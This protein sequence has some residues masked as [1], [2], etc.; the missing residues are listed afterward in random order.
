MSRSNIRTMAVGARAFRNHRMFMQQHL[1]SASRGRALMATNRAY[2]DRLAW[3]KRIEDSQA[4]T[5]KPYNIEYDTFLD[6]YSRVVMAFKINR[7][8]NANV[9]VFAAPQNGELTNNNKILPAFFAPS[10]IP[11]KGRLIHSF[12]APVNTVDM[13]G[14]PAFI[15]YPNA[16][17]NGAPVFV[18]IANTS[19]DSEQNIKAWRQLPLDKDGSPLFVA[20]PNHQDNNGRPVFVGEADAFDENKNLIYVGPERYGGIYGSEMF[21]YAHA[22]YI[23]PA[24]RKL[25]IAYENQQFD[26]RAAF[27]ARFNFIRPLNSDLHPRAPMLAIS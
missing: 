27:V 11:A 5:P 13:K 14:N 4:K 24:G 22:N 1:Q 9:E 7:L 19:V 16:E 3:Q 26:G 21:F 6:A 2:R 10:E 25:F 18:A 17:H 23:D 12:A 15:A 20:F 8:D